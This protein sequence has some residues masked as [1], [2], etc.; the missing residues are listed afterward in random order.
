MRLH[1]TEDQIQATVCAWLERAL[2]EDAVFFAVPNGGHRHPAVAAKL[3]WTGTR[4]GIPDLCIV[5]RGRPIF[6][7]LKAKGGSLS[8]DQRA[9]HE[10]LTLAGA[11]VL[12]VAR[13]VDEVADF[14]EALGMPLRAAVKGRAVA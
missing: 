10:R 13:S 5:W 2:P 9:M 4:K 11:I 7:E 6:I 3:K 12:P 8:P 1:P 14:L